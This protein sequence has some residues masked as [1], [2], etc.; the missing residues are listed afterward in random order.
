MCNPSPKCHA[1]WRRVAG[2]R[3]SAAV[4]TH[5]CA[6]AALGPAPA[7]L[8]LHREDLTGDADRLL[9][10]VEDDGSTRWQRSFSKNLEAVRLM[11]DTAI[12]RE[13]GLLSVVDLETGHLLWQYPRPEHQKKR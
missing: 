11:H 5:A 10:R 13:W 4:Q 12:L 6:A 1:R 2:H 8:V 3:R 7:N 9:S